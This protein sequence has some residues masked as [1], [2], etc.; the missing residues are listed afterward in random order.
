MEVHPLDFIPPLADNP[1]EA[2]KIWVRLGSPAFAKTSVFAKA[3][4]FAAATEDRLMDRSA[5]EAKNF[6]L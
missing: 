4:S 3:S 1:P 6:R 5:G 2:D